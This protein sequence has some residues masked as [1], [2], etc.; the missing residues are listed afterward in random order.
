[1]SLQD[2]FL[3]DIRANPDDDSPRKATGKPVAFKPRGMS[4]AGTPLL[5]D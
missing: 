4:S 2:A 3:R 1:M 5:T